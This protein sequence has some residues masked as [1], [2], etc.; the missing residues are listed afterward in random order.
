MIVAI[1]MVLYSP[2]LI[3][4]TP[5]ADDI[6]R[7]VWGLNENIPVGRP[8]IELFADIVHTNGPVTDLRPTS[9]IIAILIFAAVGLLVVKRYGQHLPFYARVAGGALVASPSFAIGNMAYSFDAPYMAAALLASVSASIYSE[10]ESKLRYVTVL[11]LLL[12]SLCLYQPSISAFITITA[13]TA[14]TSKREIG[15]VFLRCLI[16]ASIL[17][18][19]IIIYIICYK[20]F[21]SP[22]SASYAAMHSQINIISINS[23]FKF[24]LSALHYSSEVYFGGIFKFVCL[25]LTAM[26][27]IYILGRNSLSNCVSILCLAVVLVSPFVIQI[28]LLAPVF[29]M[30]SLYGFGVV[31]ALLALSAS[32]RTTAPISSS[33][34]LMMLLWGGAMVGAFSS[35]L[36]IQRDHELAL[37]SRAMD[38]VF[39]DADREPIITV[40]GDAGLV[41]YAVTVKNKYPQLNQM[42]YPIL[43]NT[44]LLP[45]VAERVGYKNIHV[46]GNALPMIIGKG[47][48][49]RVSKSDNR[50]HIN[51]VGS[52]T[53]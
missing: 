34:A 23:I 49:Y 20:I 7:Q 25:A 41:D 12:I 39:A 11:F 33:I 43:S 13:F 16:N 45:A 8:L 9:Q 46:G 42:I 32:N 51:F 22:K 52:A 2:L 1:Y 27:L 3:N 47:Y 28:A 35:A 14:A 26:A 50:Y 40:S 31:F 19:S 5:Y 24:A 44:W 36:T 15:P 10:G 29:E 30:R 21:M 17:L 37:I 6:T 48:Q 53:E 18:I 4:T 38:M